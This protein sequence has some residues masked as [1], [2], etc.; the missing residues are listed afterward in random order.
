M[1][2]IVLISSLSE[3]LLEFKATFLSEMRGALG[4]GALWCLNMDRWPTSVM[5]LLM[6]TGAG[7]LNS[8]YPQL[9]C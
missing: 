4:P 3:T 1:E 8:I 5:L 7:P 9:L 2:R 6:G